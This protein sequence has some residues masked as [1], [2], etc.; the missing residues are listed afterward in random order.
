VFV[1][2]SGFESVYLSNRVVVMRPRPGRVFAEIAIDAGQ[3]RDARFRTSAAY[4][5]YCRLA[6]E[7][8]GGAMQAGDA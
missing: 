7:A 6:F 2:H 3:P 8:L 5:G 1:T 4:G